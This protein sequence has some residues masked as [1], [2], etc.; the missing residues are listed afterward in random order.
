MT[1]NCTRFGLLILIASSNGLLL[2][3][4]MQYTI[5]DLGSSS[6]APISGGLNDLG[7]VAFSVAPPYVLGM[8]DRREQLLFFDGTSVHQIPSL[9]GE[10]ASFLDI[11]NLGTMVGAASS[12]EYYTYFHGIGLQPYRPI[13]YEGNRVELIETPETTW[14]IA[15]SI[16]DS[17]Q[18]VGTIGTRTGQHSFFWDPVTGFQDLGTFG[19]EVAYP[20]DINNNADVLIDSHDEGPI[21]YYGDYAYKGMQTL[22]Y[23]EGKVMRLPDPGSH[24]ISGAAINNRGQ[25]AGAY[26]TIP[27]KEGRAFIWD[28]ENGMTDIGESNL[29][30]GAS[31]INDNGV[32]V[33]SY[34]DSYP[35]FTS[36]AFI[37][38]PEF[39]R[40]RL[41]DLLKNNPGWIALERASDIN[42]RGQIFGTGRHYG[43][44]E[45]HAFLVTPVPEPSAAIPIAV[46]YLSTIL[47]RSC[48]RRLVH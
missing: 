22:V 38:D 35:N 3:G 5:R 27:G 25:I 17:N 9:G 24:I 1:T 33:G 36:D 2:A 30:S 34:S 45:W 29:L 28:S 8:S 6:A 21:Y 48:R 11:N 14:A 44:Y 39:G 43:S 23:N 13:R 40:R 26:A 7:Q 18:I 31:D 47:G 12:P 15:D 4:P 19:G 16:N 20:V 32:A 10:F 41:I 46:A 42:N 37:Y